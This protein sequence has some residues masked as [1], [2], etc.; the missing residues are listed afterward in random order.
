MCFVKLEDFLRKRKCGS[1]KL[2]LIPTRGTGRKRERKGTLR[3]EA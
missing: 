3:K 2:E 1:Q